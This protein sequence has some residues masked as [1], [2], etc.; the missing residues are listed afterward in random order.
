MPIEKVWKNVCA[1]LNDQRVTV[2]TT[3]AL[4]EEV[5]ATF[6]NLCDTDYTASLK[7]I[8]KS[9]LQLVVASHCDWI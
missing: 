7:G 3:E 6:D 2:H 9:K 5:K 1:E 4:F 8:L